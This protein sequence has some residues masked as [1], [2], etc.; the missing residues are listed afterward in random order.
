MATDQGLEDSLDTLRE[1][2]GELLRIQSNALRF[3]STHDAEQCERGGDWRLD[4]A[5]EA[6]F[7]ND[8]K[9]EALDL[10]IVARTQ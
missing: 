8:P 5:W 2:R 4:I 9:I 7:R 3:L 10:H 6:L 1:R